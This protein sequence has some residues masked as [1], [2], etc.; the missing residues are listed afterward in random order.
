[1]LNPVH[2]AT[3]QAVLRSNSF[4]AAAR[5][6]GYTAS[7]VSQQMRALERATGLD[8]FERMPRSIRPTAAAHYLAAAG[9]QMVLGLHSLEHDAHALA[10]AERG[11]IT[12]GSFR[13]ASA[14]IL[15]SAF[16][17][18]AE[19]RPAV[20]MELSEGE[21]DDLIPHVLSGALDL[22]L[23]YE[24]DLNPQQWPENLTRIPLLTEERRLLMPPGEKTRRGA[25]R[26]A[27]LRD[28]TWVASAPSPSLTRYSAAAGFE[29]RVALRT[30][31]YYSVCEFVRAGLGIALVPVMGHY[32]PETLRPVKLR[33]LP[34]R[35]HVSALHRPSNTS[36]LL[37]PLI[38]ELRRSARAAAKWGNVP[39]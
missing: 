19:K 3:L 32:L 34:P 18:F 2:L 25:V 15:P 38:D 16:A 12:I 33:P 6:L 13:T 36:P 28:R 31:D 29:P 5:D 24:N 20:T 26:L 37:A 17:A 27:D 21:P 9:R 1:M 35:R 7:A 30:N 22:A 8:L 11:H 39:A 23:V 10:V 4:V 14:R